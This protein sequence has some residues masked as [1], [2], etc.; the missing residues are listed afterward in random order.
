MSSGL[1]EIHRSLVMSVFHVSMSDVLS[2]G[3]RIVFYN[4]PATAACSLLPVLYVYVYN[5]YSL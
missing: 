4:V 2:D 5:V 1:Y 3:A